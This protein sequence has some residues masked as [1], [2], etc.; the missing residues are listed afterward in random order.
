MQ[1]SLISQEN[2]ILPWVFDD[3]ID[4]NT[5][6]MPFKNLNSIDLVYREPDILRSKKWTLAIKDT[7]TLSNLLGNQICSC[8]YKR[9]IIKV[10]QRN[11]I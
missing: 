5:W 4:L 8:I 3:K 11:E 6:I 9:N 1:E 10:L 7:I 2:Y